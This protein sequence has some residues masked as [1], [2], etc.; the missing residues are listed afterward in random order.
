[1]PT[2]M[3]YVFSG[4]YSPLV[5]KFIEQVCFECVLVS[6]EYCN[7]KLPVFS[8]RRSG[9]TNR[10]VFDAGVEQRNSGRS[11]RHHQAPA[12]PHLLGE[13]TK[14]SEKYVEHFSEKNRDLA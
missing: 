6:D 11:G 4:A 8:L 7:R 13:E 14:I 10:I 5:C 1:M 3:S 2:D 9:I 12:W